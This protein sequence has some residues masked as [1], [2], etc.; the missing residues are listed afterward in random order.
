MSEY[1]HE[2]YLTPQG[3]KLRQQ[4]SDIGELTEQAV[5]I[6]GIAEEIKMGVSLPEYS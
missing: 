1:T 6:R 2:L 5:I 3:V 4:L